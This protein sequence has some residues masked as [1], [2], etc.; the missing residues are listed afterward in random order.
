MN[1][2]AAL[3]FTFL[4]A[5][6]LSASADEGL[7]LVGDVHG[8]LESRMKER[9]LLLSAAQ[10]HD[11]EGSGAAVSDAVVR[12]GS[13]YTGSLIS[14]DGLILT[15]YSCAYPAVARA[16]TLEEDFLENGF[17]AAGRNRELP[18]PGETVSFLRK[19]LDVTAEVKALK[20]ELGS[21]GQSFG[22]DR[23]SRLM[24]ERYAG[25]EPGLEARFSSVYSG[26]RCFISF[27]KVYSDVRLVAA[28][29]S[30]LGCFGGSGAA[31]LWPHHSCD[32][33]I[34]RIYEGGAPVSGEKPLKLSLKGYSPFSFTMV[35]GF[36]LQTGRFSPSGLVRLEEEALVPARNSVRAPRIAIL[37][38]WTAAD[39]EIRHK[40]APLYQSLSRDY[41]GGEGAA[42][43]YRR[44]RTPENLRAR[45]SGLQT[46]IGSE[47]LY[48]SMWNSVITDVN[49]A[50]SDMRRIERDRALCSEI[51]S[52][53]LPTG[54]YLLRAAGCGSRDEAREILSEGIRSTDSRVERELLILMLTEFY[55]DFDSYYYGPWQ[56]KMQNRF[57][58]DFGAMADYLWENSIVSS[59]MA[60]EGLNEV[61]DLREDPLVRFLSDIPES[62][63]SMRRGHQVI[64]ARAAGLRNEY[65]RALYWMKLMKGEEMYP[66]AN[67]TMRLSYGKVAGYMPSDGIICNW[68]STPEGFLERCDRNDRDLRLDQK[69]KAMLEKHRWGRWGFP[70]EGKNKS[71]IADFLSDNDV[72]EGNSGS[73]VLNAKGE[74]IGIVSDGNYESFA[75]VVSYSPGYSMSINTDIRFVLWVLDKYAGMKRLVREIEF[76]D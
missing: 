29:P 44:F 2:A 76:A 1:R 41:S 13:G 64:S 61:A 4:F 50:Y 58:T 72:A 70:L 71:M 5:M 8:T 59:P 3:L 36:P 7:W 32:F 20:K 17:W 11:P 22:A 30:G 54:E 24:E 73:P 62:I 28:P 27:Y 31:R 53:G 66:D 57:G 23:I 55:T 18:V 63:F 69:S 46:W 35:L 75:S 42:D 38:K 48:G 65:E 49:Q 15:S 56:R 34:F 21:R 12:M 37:R 51:L 74:L 67:S 19:T 33:A 39:P 6:S 9:G 14:E 26:E 47:D 45:E 68:Y 43:C 40:Y 10:I 52:K 16:S 60:A 25:A